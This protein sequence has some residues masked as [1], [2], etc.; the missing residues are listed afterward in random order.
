[1]PETAR[2]VVSMAHISAELIV[3]D[4]SHPANENIGHMISWY[5]EFLSNGLNAAV[6]GHRAPQGRSLIKHRTS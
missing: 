2:S 5:D 4:A 1:M 3:A 6:A